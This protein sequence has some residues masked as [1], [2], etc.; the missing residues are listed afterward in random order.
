[1][2]LRDIRPFRSSNGGW[3]K[4][5]GVRV[6]AGTTSTSWEEGE[7]LV[8]DAAAG[9]ANVAPDGATAA[10]NLT[11]IATAGSSGLQSVYGATDTT[12]TTTPP[13]DHQVTGYILSDEAEFITDNVFNNS[14]TNIGP[15]GTGALTG[16][17][18]GATAGFWHDLTAGTGDQGID[19]NGSTL[20][21]TGW[22]DA[23]LNPTLTAADAAWV[24][25]KR[26]F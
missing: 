23:N 6:G 15:A 12:W 21:I 8:I 5:E 16:A 1:M 13:A 2:S 11:I 4:V 20:I 18:P 17:L 14:D 24:S 26:N 7:V 10:S 3:E 19:V 25:F 22:L 9:D